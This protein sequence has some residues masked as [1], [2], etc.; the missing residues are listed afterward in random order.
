MPHLSLMTYGISTCPLGPTFTLS[1]TVGFQV[2][3]W[4]T[5]KL[6]PVLCSIRRVRVTEKISQVLHSISCMRGRE[7]HKRLCAIALLLVVLSASASTM[8]AT[9]RGNSTPMNGVVLERLTVLDGQGNIRNFTSLHRFLPFTPGQRACR[10]GCADGQGSRPVLLH[11]SYEV[12]ANRTRVT[13]VA[14]GFSTIKSLGLDAPVRKAV[15]G[16]AAELSA[17]Q[18][19]SRLLNSRT[20]FLLAVLMDPDECQTD[21]DCWNKYGYG[22]DYCYCSSTCAD[23]NWNCVLT[24]ISVIGLRG[25]AFGCETFTPVCG[26]CLFWCGYN[27]GLALAQGGCCNRWERGC[28]C[29]N[30]PTAP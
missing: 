2:G 3:P 27:L 18:R 24:W 25:C 15:A 26:Y 11:Y 9:P 22:Y 8:V 29:G 30:Y 13:G 4:K 17:D 28:T 21:E 6:S 23:I 7:F 1:S 19:T 10:T 12:L 20:R 14:H 5:Y 16:L